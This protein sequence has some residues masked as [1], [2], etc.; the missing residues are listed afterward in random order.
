MQTFVKFFAFRKTCRSFNSHF[1]AA[2]DSFCGSD[3]GI[4]MA[5]MLGKADCLVSGN[6]ARNRIDEL[7]ISGWKTTPET[8]PAE[9]LNR[10]QRA[11]HSILFLKRWLL[12]GS[13]SVIAA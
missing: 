4:A 13:K 12:V 11:N 2:Y 8:S 6:E 5:G 3:P 9:S 1:T 7:D 10:G